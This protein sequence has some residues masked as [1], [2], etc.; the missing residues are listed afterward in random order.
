M[1][2][3][4]LCHECNSMFDS[5]QGCYFMS[6]TSSTKAKS[7]KG[8]GSYVYEENFRIAMAL[9]CVRTIPKH[10]WIND[11]DVYLAPIIKEG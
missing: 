9:Y 4:F 8:L 3:L 10:N 7:I 5:R 11:P 6:S 2:F 1:H